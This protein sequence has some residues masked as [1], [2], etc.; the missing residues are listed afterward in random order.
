MVI[1]NSN[2][3]QY[4]TNLKDEQYDPN[5]EKY[6]VSRKDMRS[7][8]NDICNNLRHPITIID[9]NYDTRHFLDSRVDSDASYYA[10]RSTCRNLRIAAGEDYCMKC[11]YFYA[12]YC[13]EL[14][15]R[16]EHK[17]KP[18]DFFAESCKNYLPNLTTENGRAFLV[19]DC[20]MLGYCEMCYPIY[21][22]AKIIG[23]LFVGEILLE[24][25]LG[26]KESIANEFMAQQ[27]QRILGDYIHKWEDKHPDN[28]FKEACITV[29]DKPSETILDD[30]GHNLSLRIVDNKHIL[31]DTEF[32][33]LIKQ[34]C[35]EVENLEGYLKEKWM[36]KRAGYYHN[37]IK[38]IKNGFDQT[39]NSIRSQDHITY[40][41]VQYLLNIIWEVVAEIKNRFG[42]KYC[43]L[44]ENLP[45]IG[46]EPSV[47][48]T[49]LQKFG[50]CKYDEEH[51][52]CNFSNASLSM[53]ICNSSLN[54]S[55]NNPLLCFSTDSQ[56]PIDSA[57]NVALAC[58][59]LAVLFG[60][61]TSMELQQNENLPILFQEISRLFLHMSTDL[62]RISTLFIQQQHEKTLH[63]Y[64]HECAHLA[65]R[66]QTNNRYYSNR[67]RYEFLSTEK[68][69]NIY[70]DIKS[71]A[72]MLQHLSTNIGLLLGSVN[73][74]KLKDNYKNVDIRDELNK[75][76]AMFRLELKKRNL[77]I[78]NTTAPLDYNIQFNTHEDLLSIILY[79]L[80]D[81][82]IKYAYWGTN[83]CCEVLPDQISIKD[84]GI[85]IEPG[86]RPYDMYYR[87]IR[88]VG[89]N[90]GDGIGLYSSKRAA[91]IL[92]LELFHTC[93]KVS[94]YN[95]P[96]VVEAAKRKIAIEGFDFAQAIKELPNINTREI[97]TPDGYYNEDECR[98]VERTIKRG[99]NKATYCVTFTIKGL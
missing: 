67:E 21:F 3:I 11:D 98:I 48:T 10:L 56:F 46:R 22:N 69:E 77:R 78:F 75:W 76:R 1:H 83:I 33:S 72:L 85:E 26:I 50:E 9:V 43:R 37:I 13:K 12:Q 73:R 18:L 39:Y 90:L 96:F 93:K 89:N 27:K 35:K 64:R 29:D 80:I 84:Y 66:I 63:M 23:F 95:I 88:N 28:K 71:V 32:N 58:E 54:N 57:T 24:K 41:E 55:S 92:G 91:N 94:N 60:I 15:E 20:P 17:S 68:K 87:D 44:F 2:Q 30:Y 79:N 8:A 47:L 4:I 70:R 81:N 65:Q 86:Y 52:T 36:E 82:A 34:C 38:S 16:K 31:T 6:I 19:Y 7:K 5:S 51:L 61:E 49:D 74:E 14:L 97:L 59:N 25:K 40:N 45:Y 53:T 62:D 42:F 99:I